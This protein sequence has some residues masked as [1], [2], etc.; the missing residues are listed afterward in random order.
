MKTY[1]KKFTALTLAGLMLASLP[2]AAFA[3]ETTE[4][5]SVEKV[6][7]TE[8]V[9]KAVPAAEPEVK[10]EKEEVK[11]P[12]ELAEEKIILN[13]S[14][15]E[16]K[17]SEAK[18]LLASTKKVDKSLISA[19]ES[20]IRSAE[21]TLKT[22]TS[23]DE[24]D[25]VV[26]SLENAISAIKNAQELP[27]QMEPLK[28]DENDSKEK[29][30]IS[31]DLISGAVFAQ[32][33]EATKKA[34]EA[35]V[36]EA[37]AKKDTAAYKNASEEAKKEFDDAITDLETAYQANDATNESINA[38]LGKLVAL[39]TALDSNRTNKTE[40]EKEIVS[41]KL[42]KETSKYKNAD[43][44]KKDTFDKA[45]T[46]AETVNSNAQATQKEVDSA[47]MA[48]ITAREALDGK[49]SVL[50][51]LSITS[52]DINSSGYVYG[53]V[54][55]QNGARVAGAT[56]TFYS[57]GG[58]SVASSTTDANGYFNFYV[59]TS[60]YYDYY[61][62]YDYYNGRHYRPW[63]NDWY[64]GYYYNGHNIYHDSNGYYYYD[65]NN[66]K[67]YEND[68]YRYWDGYYDT[69]YYGRSGY[70]VASKDGV[71]SSKDYIYG[72]YPNWYY[73]RPSYK[74]YDYYDGYRV[75]PTSVSRGY[76]ST[77]GYLKGYEGKT[78]YVYDGSTYLGSDVISS[79][80]YF[81][82]TWSY[83]SISTGRSLEYYINGRRYGDYAVSPVVKEA[84]A[85]LS[86]VKGKA[87]NG[88]AI[89]VKDSLD[90]KLGQTTADSDGDF[91]V[92]LNRNLRA[93]E[94]I[95]VIA[96]EGS[97]NDSQTSYIVTGTALTG[98]TFS[99]ISYIKGYPDG[100]FRPQ[101]NVT[102]GEAAQMFATLLNGSANFGTSSVTKFS[103]AN[104]AWYSQAINYV[105]GKN[106]IAGYEDG[107][108][109][110]NQAI[111]RAEFAQMISGYI[112][113]GFAGTGG[114]KDVKGHWASE[115]I[116]KVY[117]NR[118]VA[119]YPDGTFKP[120]QNI[121]RAE[122]VTIL[123]SVFNR[124]TTVDSL[125]NVSVSSLNTFSDVSKGF[126]AYYQIIDA[127]NAHTSQKVTTASDE[128][129]W[130]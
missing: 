35:A 25:A 30:E 86:V 97:R 29:L 19:L 91:T 17:I 23:Q 113:A 2:L 40:L 79:S 106:L 68:W 52:S 58:G 4:G 41:S 65:I 71:S 33:L 22:A 56:V 92:Y 82:V 50:T 53:Y 63:Y 39:S 72:Y 110:P 98:D 122:A 51:S 9:K 42:T 18:T 48:L 20:S 31:D 120:N 64:N 16:A 15:L 112:K 111:T 103:D 60:Y 84:N 12:E 66:N 43:K 83:P 100:K 59:G 49:A 61:D 80:G 118:T 32:D 116:D 123:N 119:G 126:W 24:I 95:K 76:Y 73:D 128:E 93:G 10:V 36:K 89:V 3:E 108:F 54:S 14:T 94:T 130:K 88:A 105:V 109:K 114:F 104:N 38:A 7:S 44:D 75:Y 81:S 69:R 55:D 101:A 96:S 5:A 28:A 21:A 129:V 1:K 127:A 102:R 27:E 125:A 34:A 57:Y 115:A 26:S 13:T 121:T 6:V 45:L 77:N 46:A 74:W 99:R 78:V 11:T 47:K 87:G 67:V 107:T 90:N 8:E 117:G 124:Y 85:G 62:Y 37:K 70:L